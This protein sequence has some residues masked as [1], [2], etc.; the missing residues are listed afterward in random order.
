MNQAISTSSM[1]EEAGLLGGLVIALISNTIY[2]KPN[3][4]RGRE[5]KIKKNKKTL[6][7]HTRLKSTQ[8]KRRGVVKLGPPLTLDS[9]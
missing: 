9:V 4:K 7:E 5:K 6:A 1:L 8:A 3:R 2:V